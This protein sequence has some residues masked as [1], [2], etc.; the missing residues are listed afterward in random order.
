MTLSMLGATSDRT[1]CWEA[2]SALEAVVEK[3]K[4]SAW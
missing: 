4:I 2:R 3:P 1:E